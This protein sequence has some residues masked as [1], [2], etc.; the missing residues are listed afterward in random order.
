MPAQNANKKP[1]EN[2][3]STAQRVKRAWPRIEGQSLKQWARQGS[4]SAETKPLVLDWLFNKKANTS[5]PAQG[6]G[7]TNR[8]SKG[9]K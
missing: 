3:P 4:Q 5:K 6:I 7:R 2:R 9:K 1:A 8:I